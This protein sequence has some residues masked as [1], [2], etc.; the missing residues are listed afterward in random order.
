MI[1]TYYSTTLSLRNM[2]TDYEYPDPYCMLTLT[3]YS[4]AVLVTGCSG[5][6]LCC[7]SPVRSAFH[8]QEIR[9]GLSW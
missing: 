3:R 7:A 8:A 4:A 6:R 2:N 5:P 9:R 1:L